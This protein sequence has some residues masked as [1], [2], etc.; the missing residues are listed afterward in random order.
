M[1]RIREKCIA[2]GLAT[3]SELD[4]MTDHQ[5]QQ[6]IFAPGFS[7]AQQ[8]GELSGRGVGMD[9]VRTYIEE[10]GGTVRVE[11][12]VGKGTTFVLTL[13]KPVSPVSEGMAFRVGRV[14]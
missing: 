8:V 2:N 3:E 14:V 11:T 9:V 7:T 6:F 13:P 4:D 5:I 10:A 12:E 1:G